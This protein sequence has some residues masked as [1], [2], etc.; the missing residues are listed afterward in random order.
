MADVMFVND[1]P[2][3]ITM[4][5]SI[6]DVTI[7]H[8]PNHTSNK[9]SEYLKRVMKIYSRSSMLVKTVFVDMDSDNTIDKLM[10]NIIVNTS[11]TK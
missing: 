1:T 3:L 9:L 10:E 4:S 5:R 8:V 7:K 6:N 2:L 11:D